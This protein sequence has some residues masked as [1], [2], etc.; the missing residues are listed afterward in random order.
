MK[1]V[2][3]L[4]V[5]VFSLAYPLLVYFSYN[6]ID[7]RFFAALFLAIAI[8]RFALTYKSNSHKPEAKKTDK[9]NLITLLLLII[10]CAALVLTH[11]NTLLRLYPVMMS[12]GFALLFGLSLLGETSLIE[13][14]ARRMGKTITSNAK[15]YTR[16][17]T[18]IWT[19]LLCVNG[20]I[21]LYLALFSSM[22]AWTAYCGLISYLIMGSFFLGE[23]IFRQY[24]IRRYG[25]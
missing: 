4:V 6:R 10:Y 21:A 8:A 22:A 2:I 13:G 5:T 12:F 23:T 20:V 15:H 9:K 7:S 1:I 3:G 14:F 17:L 16:R 18:Y 11:S 24:Y 19:V 25:E